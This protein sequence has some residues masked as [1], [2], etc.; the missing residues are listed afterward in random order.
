MVTPPV[1]DSVPVPVIFPVQVTRLPPSASAPDVSANAVATV[2]G[3]PSVAEP[4]PLTVNVTILFVV[5]GVVG[6]RNKVP[7]APVAP[8]V[9]L[10][11]ALPV[12]YLVADI[13]ATVPFNVS[14]LAPTVSVLPAAVKVKAPAIVGLPDIVNAVAPA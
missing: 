11:E 14:V 13:L 1:P 9:K 10:E 12:I 5:P 7:R 6:F 3:L 8:I 4:P 2:M